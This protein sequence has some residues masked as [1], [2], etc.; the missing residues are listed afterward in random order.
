MLSRDLWRVHHDVAAA[1][2]AGL[3]GMWIHK[4]R[5]P[6]SN[7]APTNMNLLGCTMYLC[8]LSSV[9]MCCSGF[10]CLGDEQSRYILYFVCMR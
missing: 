6:M 9:R 3:A 5:T 2:D 8:C 1:V 7:K 10:V 4:F